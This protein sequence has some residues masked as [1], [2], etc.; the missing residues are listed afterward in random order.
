MHRHDYMCLNEATKIKNIEQMKYNFK[1]F[2]IIF[3]CN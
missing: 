3:V 2:G 1:E